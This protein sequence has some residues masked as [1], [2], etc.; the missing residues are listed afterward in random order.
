MT[1]NGKTYLFG[2]SAKGTL[3][4]WDQNAKPAIKSVALKSGFKNPFFL[5]EATKSLVSI[6]SSGTMYSVSLDG[7]V[8]M[9]PF[10]KSISNP[11]F[12]YIEYDAQTKYEND[13]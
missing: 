9:K 8:K 11:Y 12:D 5:S 3:Y 7:T 10:P 13:Y 6:D 1:G 4:V 2:G